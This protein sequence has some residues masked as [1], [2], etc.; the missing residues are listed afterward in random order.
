MK[1]SHNE[2]KINNG[3]KNFIEN[4][5]ALIED[6]DFRKLYKRAYS[7]RSTFTVGY[8]THAL[9]SIGI[10]PLDDLDYIPAGFLEACDALIDVDIPD[11]IEHIDESAFLIAII[12]SQ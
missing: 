8:L 2:P 7:A 10:D 12:L 5:I 11:H 4:N 9:Y 6:R 1:F 3:L